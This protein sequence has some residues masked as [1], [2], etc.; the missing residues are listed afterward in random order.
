MTM[1]IV[2]SSTST[3][4]TSTVSE[5]QDSCLGNH[6]KN[7]YYDKGMMILDQVDPMISVAYKDGV[8]S[9]QLSRKS[10]ESA[11]SLLGERDDDLYSADDSSIQSFSDEILAE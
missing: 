8:N 4:M 9:Q 7:P 10:T 2:N 3:E 5:D 1:S 11:E 6:Q